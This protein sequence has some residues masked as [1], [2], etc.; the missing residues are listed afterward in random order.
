MRVWLLRGRAGAA[1]FVPTSTGAA[2]AVTDILPMYKGIKLK[3]EVVQFLASK[4]FELVQEMPPHGTFNCA[5]D[6]VFL[7]KNTSPAAQQ[8]MDFLRKI[9]S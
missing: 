4:G 7:K 8:K 2:K 1:N 6:C 3:D 5:C 9:Y